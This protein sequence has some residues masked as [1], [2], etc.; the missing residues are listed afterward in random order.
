MYAWNRS[1]EPFDRLLSATMCSYELLDLRTERYF[2]LDD[3][4]TRIWQLLLEHTSLVTVFNMML[5]EYD[6][7]PA[8]LEADLLKHISELADSSLVV[9]VE[10]CEAPT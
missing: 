10:S 3:V 6:V 9:L 2:G 8:R 1:Y 5:S 7:D 4:G